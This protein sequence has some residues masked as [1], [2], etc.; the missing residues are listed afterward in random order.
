MINATL[1]AALLTA[2]LT[3]VDGAAPGVLPPEG[4]TR[5]ELPAKTVVEIEIVDTVS[6]K[7]AKIGDMFEIRLMEPV[8]I[9]GRLVLPIGLAGRGQVS[10]VAKAGWGGKAGELIVMVRYLQCGGD[11]IPIGRFHFVASG[12]SHAGAAFGASVIVPFAGFFIDGGEMILQAGTRGNA[13]VSAAID[14]P[15]SDRPCSISS[16]G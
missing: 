16:Q 13:K 12:E 1:I 6:S 2:A 15:V 8:R 5:L 14:L 11:Q 7:T 4:P 9:D 3:G 10:H